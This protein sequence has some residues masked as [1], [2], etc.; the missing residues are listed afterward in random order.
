MR[1]CVSVERRPLPCPNLPFHLSQHNARRVLDVWLDVA[2]VCPHM[3]CVQGQ[4]GRLSVLCCFIREM[5]HVDAVPVP[6]SSRCIRTKGEFFN[7]AWHLGVFINLKPYSKT[8]I[9]HQFWFQ[10]SQS[11]TRLFFPAGTR[12][13]SPR[14]ISVVA[15]VSVAW[16]RACAR[17][18]SRKVCCIWQLLVASCGW[19]WMDRWFVLRPRN[20]FVPAM[21]FACLAQLCAVA[22][23]W[24]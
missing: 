23:T 18:A 12:T 13:W 2:H 6:S 5:I 14:C 24:I 17:A 21:E 20:A 3:H 7:W 22:E 11:Y 8:T 4:V 15:A 19:E 9:S 10:V 1:A 16:T